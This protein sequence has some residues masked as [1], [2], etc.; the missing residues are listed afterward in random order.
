MFGP[1]ELIHGVLVPAIVCG[2]VLAAIWASRAS[3]GDQSP[4]RRQWTALAIAAGFLAGYHAIAGLPVLPSES[5][6]LAAL[7]WMPWLVIAAL[8]VSLVQSFSAG[9]RVPSWIWSALVCVLVVLLSFLGKLGSDAPWLHFAIMAAVLFLAWQSADALA[10][11]LPGPAVP[12]MLWVVA[13]AT[14]V[15]AVLSHSAK[16]A[17]LDGA[18]AAC[19]G[20]CVVVALW[21]PLLSAAGGA[22]AIA[23]TVLGVSWLNAV[24]YADLPPLAGMLLIGAVVLP[25]FA[26]LGHTD[27][28]S[29]TKKVVVCA[30]LAA[31]P[32][33]AAVVVAQLSAPS[34]EY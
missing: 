22:V 24:H 21:N 10:R 5:R 34:Y 27:S 23:M 25:W 2:L 32:A 26:R 12:A 8:V 17:Q 7:D 1:N 4:A 15:S 14:A 6:R 28:W 20:A 3:G 18:L 33:V 9:R 11:K 31:L 19:L 13:T 29:R 16:I 30:A